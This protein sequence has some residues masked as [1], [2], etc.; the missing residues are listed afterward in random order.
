MKFNSLTHKGKPD[1]NFFVSIDGED[2]EKASKK[3]RKSGRYDSMRIK[4]V[5]SDSSEDTDSEI[6]EPKG[7][8][9][10]RF[11]QLGT[12]NYDH[13][14]RESPKFLIGEPVSA[15]VINDKF[16]V[17]AKLYKESEVA[18]DVWDTMIMLK[19]A[20]S[21]RHMGFSIEGKAIER[22]VRNPKI[23][24]KALI[25][26]L[27]VTMSPKNANSYADI[28][29]GG[30]SNPLPEYTYEDEVDNDNVEKSVQETN[31][32]KVKYLVDITNPENGMRYTVDRDLN[33]KVE[34]AMDTTTAKPLIKES[35]EGDKKKKKAILNLANAAMTGTI[36]KSLFNRA[37][38]LFV[39]NKAIEDGVLNEDILE[40]AKYIKREKKGG[41]W[42]YTYKEGSK[43]GKKEK[44][45]E[46]KDKKITSQISD[47]K[48]GDE[49]KYFR[50]TK[51]DIKRINKISKNP[52]EPYDIT[53]D[54]KVV[55]VSKDMMGGGSITLEYIDNVYGKKV[56]QRVERNQR[57][58]NDMKRPLFEKK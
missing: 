56:K 35:L 44:V 37:K 58:L 45:E 11:L 40:K 6:L 47:F 46:K 24:K 38:S 10:S 55:D 12:I 34:K 4:G 5:A 54:A 33:L 19:A 57:S 32:G 16:H 43:G 1:F 18:R 15:K 31:G 29:K 48:V 30:Y 28:V 8:E 53:Y 26:G 42:V 7:F 13:K 9:L 25:T 22:D 2:L 23:V 3:D 21:T 17:E 52:V 39:V 49:V 27:A 36:T 20:K 14:L 50:T 51:E 41:K